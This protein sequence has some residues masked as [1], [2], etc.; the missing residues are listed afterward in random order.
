[1]YRENPL[2]TLRR[3]PAAHQCRTQYRNPGS[4][5]KVLQRGPHFIDAQLMYGDLN[6]QMKRYAQ[7]EEAFEKG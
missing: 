2:K 6:L 1:M 7:A 5:G 3:S 4:A